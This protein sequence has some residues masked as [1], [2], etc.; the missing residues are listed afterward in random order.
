MI[1]RK[2]AVQPMLAAFGTAPNFQVVFFTI[3]E[4]VYSRE[5]APLAGFYPSVYIGA[6]WWFID[7]PEAMRRYRSAVTQ[8]MALRAGGVAAAAV[9]RQPFTLK[10]ALE[11]QA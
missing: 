8:A 3:D 11:P 6:P 9:A 10:K 5:L 1:R 4:T 7:S 2:N